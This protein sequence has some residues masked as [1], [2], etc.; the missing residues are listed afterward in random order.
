MRTNSYNS[1]VILPTQKVLHNFRKDLHH[2]HISLDIDVIFKQLIAKMVAFQFFQ[3]SFFY[4][5]DSFPC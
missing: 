2:S 1:K 4:L 5:P 3:R